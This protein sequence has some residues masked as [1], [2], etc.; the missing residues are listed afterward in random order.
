MTCIQIIKK[1]RASI[2]QGTPLISHLNYL[3]VRSLIVCGESTSGCVRASVL[4]AQRYRY[5]VGIVGECCVD[6][7]QASHWMNLFDMHQKYG[8]VIDVRTAV[9]YFATARRNAASQGFQR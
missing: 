4:D 7:T 9:D 5:R 2:F 8:E 3:G 6:R 1:Q